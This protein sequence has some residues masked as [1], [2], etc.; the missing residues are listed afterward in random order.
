MSPRTSLR[1]SV[2]FGLALA[3]GLTAQVSA[4]DLGVRGATWAVAEPD[5]LSSVEAR[6][7]EMERSGELARFER[8]ARSR[9][10]ASLEAPEPVPGIAPAVEHHSRLF[11]PAVVLDRD[12][13]LPDGTLLARAGARINPLVRMPLARDLLFIDGTREVEVEWALARADRSKIVLLAGRPL[14]LSRR[15]RRPFFFDQGGRLKARFGI[16]ATPT[17]IEAAGRRL[18]ITEIP[19][20]DD[21]GG[22]AQTPEQRP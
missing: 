22:G 9:V 5:L 10:R 14:A 12:I 7:L 1:S 20:P 6:L 4:E 17:L 21:A 2:L 19:L 13:R 15:H 16:G 11:D 8:E 18:R 3:F